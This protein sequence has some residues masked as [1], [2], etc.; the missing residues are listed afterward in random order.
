MIRKRD[1]KKVAFLMHPLDTSYVKRSKYSGV[2][3]WARFFPDFFIE[4]KIEGMKPFVNSSFFIKDCECLFVIC[5][6]TS[7]Q[8]MTLPK[9]KVISKL[10]E[11]CDLAYNEGASIISLGAYSAIASNQGELLFGKTKISL[12]TGRAYTIY[13]I[14]EQAKQYIK[15][16]SIVAIIGADGAIGSAVTS[17]AKK[18]KDISIIEVGRR[19]IN[20]AYKSDVLI[21]ATSEINKVIDIS[22]LKENA[23]IIDAAKPSD[24]SRRNVRGDIKIIDGRLVEVPEKVNFGIDF[25][26]PPN[27]IYAC[28]AEA[29]I[30]GLDGFKG[31]FCI[32]KKIP[33]EK[34]E[35]IGKLGNKWGFKIV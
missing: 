5:P 17:L 3:F 15:K 20:D 26:C 18:F 7:H 14:M 35:K 2:R 22:R 8:M 24:I 1:K 30:L 28:M 23:V 34:I 4:R 33:L 19:N 25:D 9:E 10:K 12:T 6:L 16:G 29:F 27:I 21:S 11:T 31:D 32:G 13:V